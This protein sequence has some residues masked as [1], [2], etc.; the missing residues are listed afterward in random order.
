MPLW[1]LK[2]EDQKADALWRIACPAMALIGV[3]IF[4]YLTYQSFFYTQFL[5][6]SWEEKPINVKDQPLWNVAAFVAF[7]AVTFLLWLIREKCPEKVKNGLEFLTAVIAVTWVLVIGFWWITS[8]DRVP[9]GDQAFIYGGASYF[10]EGDFGFFGHGGY[11]Q[12]Y[13]GRR[14]VV[15]SRGWRVKLFRGRG[16][17][18]MLCCRNRAF[19]LF[20]PAK[21]QSGFC[22][23]GD[24]SAFDDGMHTAGMLYQLGIRRLAKHLFSVF[25]IFIYLRLAGST[26]MVYCSRCGTFLYHG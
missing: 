14:G 18:R 8:L 13:P 16:G 10:L 9:E 21:A 25:D 24:L 5:W 23:Q 2:S 26:Q 22:D 7:A 11:C 1:N 15:F 17:V 12:I 4:L 6:I 20:D 3:V 19:G